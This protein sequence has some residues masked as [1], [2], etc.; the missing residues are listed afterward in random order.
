MVQNPN[1]LNAARREAVK[2]EM[3]RGKARNASKMR[4]TRCIPG[5]WRAE[6]GDERGSE[7]RRVLGR[8]VAKRVN[9]GAAVLQNPLAPPPSLDGWMT[10]IRVSS[11]VLADYD[12]LVLFRMFHKCDA[13]V[14]T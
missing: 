14:G 5:S 6:G 12:F 7:A 11:I 3:E 9:S 4:R 1:S 2:E 10:N 13:T 8:G